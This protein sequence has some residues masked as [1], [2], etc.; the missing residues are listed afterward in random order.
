MWETALPNPPYRIDAPVRW[1]QRNV[2]GIGIRTTSWQLLIIGD[3]CLSYELFILVD[4]D[5]DT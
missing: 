1:T 5:D 2:R 3:C 4:N